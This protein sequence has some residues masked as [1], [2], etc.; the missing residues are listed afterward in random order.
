MPIGRY[1]PTSNLARPGVCTSTTRPASP[2]EGMVIYETDT[3]RTLVWNASAWVAPNSTTANPPG[4]EL[5]NSTTIGSGVATVTTPASTFSSAYDAYRIV[6]SNISSSTNNDLLMRLN[7]GGTDATGANYMRGGVFVTYATAVVAG[8]GN[9]NLTS[10]VVSST[11]SS[12]YK[13]YGAIDLFNPFDAVYTG[14]WST[15][16]L[17]RNDIAA[18]ATSG[19]HNLNTSYDRLTF[20]PSTGTITGGTITV[21]GY[22]KA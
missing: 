12:A 17:G 16:Y 9:N 18:P 11:T 4:L 7:I 21:Y 3:D 20:L 22:R 1:I 15:A 13:H 14:F 6:L 8:F 10:F 19:N 5:V 2:Y